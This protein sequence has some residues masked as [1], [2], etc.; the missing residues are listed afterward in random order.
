MSVDGTWEEGFSNQRPRARPSLK[1]HAVAI[2]FS[3]Q[4]NLFIRHGSHVSQDNFL[5]RSY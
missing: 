1:L 4:C 3:L 2:F 5:G